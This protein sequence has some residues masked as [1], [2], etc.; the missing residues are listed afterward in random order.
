MNRPRTVSRWVEL[1]GPFLGLAVVLLL[2]AI[3]IPDRFISVSNFRTTLT[4]TV[5]VGLGA[6]G[7]TWVIVGGGIDLSVGSTIALSSVAT[8][9][10]LKFTE[11]PALALAVGMV[12]G[13][14]V[15]LLNGVLI[16]WLRLVPFIATL[17]TM[18][19]ARGIAKWLS[20]E[21]KVNAPPGWLD[22]VMQKTPEPGFLMVSIGVWITLGLGAVMAVL[23]RH[24]VIGTHAIAVG[25]SEAT[26]R[27]AG[28][29]VDRIKTG[30]Y[31]FAGAFAG[32]AGV[33]QFGRLTVGDPTTALG[34]EL[35]IIA[36]VVI[37]GGSLSGGQGSVV[38]SLVGAF[39]TTTLASGCRLMGFP[40][41]VQEI[42]IGAIIVGAV[43]IDQARRTRG[44]SL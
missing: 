5:I 1:A 18:L 21:Q 6:I 27:L 19:V 26:A 9:L 41:Y 37:G 7:M 13:M 17:G 11:S 2:F 42:L 4:Q 3:L 14:S 32:L 16:T 25:S 36:A 20:G 44:E 12:T 10:V 29:R 30:L 31:V 38:G 33:M 15:G 23:L 28:L 39:L 35:D 40:N 43:F 34:A 24:S 8:A 22:E